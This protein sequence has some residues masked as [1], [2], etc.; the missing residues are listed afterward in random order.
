M[1]V[2]GATP[3][4]LVGGEVLDPV[5]GAAAEVL[6]EPVHQLREVDGVER[7]TPVV[8]PSHIDRHPVAVHPAI[9]GSRPKS[10]ACT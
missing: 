6:P 10:E 8:V 4:A 9:A 2:M 5:A 7:R 1:Q 3:L